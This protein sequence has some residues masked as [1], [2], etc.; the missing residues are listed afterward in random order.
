MPEVCYLLAIPLR[1]QAHI[2]SANLKISDEDQKILEEHHKNAGKPEHPAYKDPFE[3]NS[4]SVGLLQ[5]LQVVHAQRT[6]LVPSSIG[7]G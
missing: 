7:S 2:N 6:D 4:I 5:N 3:V 1:E